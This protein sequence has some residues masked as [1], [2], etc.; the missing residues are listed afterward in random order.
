M[1][2]TPILSLH[3]KPSYDVL[4]TRKMAP[5]HTT[6]SS[7]KNVV[8]VQ[9]CKMSVVFV[10]LNVICSSIFIAGIGVAGEATSDSLMFI[11]HV[12][13]RVEAS[14]NLNF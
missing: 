11:L 13:E 4:P 9:T 7:Q 5:D 3:D 8:G 2:I 6:S 10:F 1:V 12:S 14:N